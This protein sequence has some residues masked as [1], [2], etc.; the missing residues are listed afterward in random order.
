[1]AGPIHTTPGRSRNGKPIDF[2]V[3]RQVDSGHW[4]AEQIPAEVLGLRRPLWVYRAR[5]SSRFVQPWNRRYEQG[6][7]PQHWADI[8]IGRGSCGLRCRGCF[9]I[10][11]HRVFCDPSRHLLYDNVDDCVRAVE[12][13]LRRPNRPSLGLGIDCSDSLLYE[14][15]T[16]YARQ[17]L[18][19]VASSESNPKGVVGV[20]LTKTA[21][22]HYLQGLP[23]KNVV[24][25]FSL[26]PEPIA[27]L[28]EG[29]FDDGVRVA[30]SIADRVAASVEAQE[31]GFQVRW[32]VDP[33][34]TPDDWEEAYR[35][36]FEDAARNGARP[37]CITLG[38]WRET[39]PSLRT[40]A[41][42][43]GLP[44]SEWRPAA[45]VKEGMHYHVPAPERIRI[46]RMMERMVRAAWR[47]T[48]H[49][50][51]L[52][53]CKEAQPVRRACGIIDAPCNCA[54]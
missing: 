49:D 27:D 7:C 30:P 21:N 14:G 46:Y 2:H 20:L 40:F 39:S 53:L 36:F 3:R 18:P 48:G 38:T 34:L 15:V 50:P 19:L 24:V 1:L 52:A 29:K 6:Y 35:C 42:E 44:P 28:W 33:I 26:N 8:K 4:R 11:T 17:I 10:A 47:G 51:M 43:W 45:L 23:R 12:R 13:W 22:V 32:R 31:M 5:R 41:D 9:L 16:G 37:G 25:S 54:S